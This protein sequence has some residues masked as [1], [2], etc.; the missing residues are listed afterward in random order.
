MR[1]SRCAIQPLAAGDTHSQAGSAA[2]ERPYWAAS[3]SRTARS[4]SD[5]ASTGWRFDIDIR[6]EN[7]AKDLLQLINQRLRLE[8]ATQ[9]GLRAQTQCH[10]AFFRLQI[11]I[12]DE[13][14]RCVAD[15]ARVTD[16]LHQF[17][18]VKLLRRHVGNEKRRV[19]TDGLGI[20][21][22]DCP[23]REDV[24]DGSGEAEGLS[25][26][27]LDEKRCAL[28]SCGWLIATPDGRRFV[29]SLPESTATRSLGLVDLASG[30]RMRMLDCPAGPLLTDIAISPDGRRLA[31]S[32]GNQKVRVWDLET[33]LCICSIH[34]DVD[35]DLEGA[36]RACFSL[37]GNLLL[38]GFEPEDDTSVWD[39]ATGKWLS[40]VD[41]SLA[42]EGMPMV[43]TRDEHWTLVRDGF[44]NGI[45]I[46]RWP[47]EK[48]SVPEIHGGFLSSLQTGVKV[49]AAC[50]YS[51]RGRIESMAMNH[52][53]LVCGLD[54]G[55]VEILSIENS[56][57][58]AIIP[59]ATPT[60]LWLFGQNNGNGGWDTALTVHCW[61]CGRRFPIEQPVSYGKVISCPCDGCGRPLQ[62]DLVACDNRGRW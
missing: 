29:C 11:V 38:T 16:A 43:S 33:G 20:R 37:D 4:C 49:R 2:A 26:R 47:R 60:R 45:V 59:L 40:G 14:Q 8:R 34:K 58:T 12:G 9:E 15:V 39:L 1:Q 41:D 42:L 3:A 52:S 46:C 55:D 35:E 19:D 18:D 51:L 36:N 57:L 54:S 23:G 28:D 50:Y 53:T 17:P 44:D 21:R 62:L 22:P 48:T 25:V 31:L 27:C 6:S 30:S 10:F 61:W 13:Q 7:P 56:P 5:S 32:H 24:A